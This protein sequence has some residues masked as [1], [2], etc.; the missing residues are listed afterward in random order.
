MNLWKQFCH[1]SCILSHYH[2]SL[3]TILSNNPLDLQVACPLTCRQF[4]S[5]KRFRLMSACA[6]CAGWHRSI[7]LQTHKAPSTQNVAHTWLYALILQGF[8]YDSYVFYINQL[9]FFFLKIVNRTSVALMDSIVNW[10]YAHRGIW[11]L[12]SERPMCFSDTDK[13]CTV[14]FDLHRQLYIGLSRQK[15][16]WYCSYL[17]LIS[18]TTTPHGTCDSL[19]NKPLT[20]LFTFVHLL[21]LL[22]SSLRTVICIPHDDASNRL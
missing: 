22:I 20:V 18:R 1:L 19:T 3:K 6:D 4:K 5:S 14:V 15:Q 21:Y 2:G 8:W 9:S 17:S 12:E 11:N 10:S 13:T 7:L 16:P